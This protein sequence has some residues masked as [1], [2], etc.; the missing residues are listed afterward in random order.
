MRVYSLCSRLQASVGGDMEGAD[1]LLCVALNRGSP[2]PKPPK[3]RGHMESILPAV[4]QE[5]DAAAHE[6]APDRFLNRELSWLAFDRRVLEEAQ[7]PNH[8]LLER[9]RF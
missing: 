2:A 9:V 5:P 7:N 6:P 3:M 8:P 1:R 4:V